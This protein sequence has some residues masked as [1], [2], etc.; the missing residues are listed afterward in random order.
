M[1]TVTRAEVI[2]HIHAA[3]AAGPAGRGDLLAAAV[4]SHARPEIIT[5]LQR[6]PNKSY[7]SPRDLW[8]DLPDVPLEA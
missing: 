6:L 2:D 3:F 7:A 5:Q 4:V 1:Q 8:Y